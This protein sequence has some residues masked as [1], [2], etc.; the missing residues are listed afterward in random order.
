MSNLR[1]GNFGV[2]YGSYYN[3]STTLSTD[4]REVNALYIY[5]YLSAR[6]WTLNAIS[7]I[8]GNIEFESGLNPGRWQGE[9]VGGGPAYGLVQWDPW[10]KYVDWCTSQGY[11]DPSEMDHNL[12]RIIYELNNGEQYYTTPSYPES[13]LEFTRSA[14]SPYYLACAFAWNYERSAVVLWGSEAEQEALRQARG[15]SAE[16][17]YRFL[18]G[19][20]PPDHP[21]IPTDPSAPTKIRKKKYKF[22]LYAK[23]RML[24]Q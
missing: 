5:N 13:F 15:S 7:G 22:V 10:T 24:H 16:K 18:S 3:E 21:D 19:E 20:E 23:R 9:N 8:L 12:A 17:W 4:Q 1:S 14:K 11:T 6:G 2:Y